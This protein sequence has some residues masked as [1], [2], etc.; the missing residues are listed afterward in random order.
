MKLVVFFL[1]RRGSVTDIKIFEHLNRDVSA[2]GGVLN[3]DKNYAV[4]KLREGL[5]WLTQEAAADRIPH[6]PIAS[7]AEVGNINEIMKLDMRAY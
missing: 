7:F 4:N 2:I 1:S 5:L 3:R 6:G